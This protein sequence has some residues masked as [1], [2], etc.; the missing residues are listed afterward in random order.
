MTEKWVH[1]GCNQGEGFIE[2]VKDSRYYKCSACGEVGGLNS[3]VTVKGENDQVIMVTAEL[4]ELPKRIPDMSKPARERWEEQ[5]EDDILRELK[6]NNFHAK[7]LYPLKQTGNPNA[8][9]ADSTSLFQ[10]DLK[11]LE[12]LAYDGIISITQRKAN[13]FDTTYLDSFVSYKIE[14]G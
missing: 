3:P 11:A 5:I 2:R 9:Q 10:S 7:D 13:S 12:A 4:I 6:N 1:S 8:A 14:H